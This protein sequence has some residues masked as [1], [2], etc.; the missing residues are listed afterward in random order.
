MIEET[1]LTAAGIEPV[2]IGIRE[3]CVEAI[4]PRHGVI[5]DLSELPREFICELSAVLTC[6]A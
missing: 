2:G 1:S 5:Q 3:A 4:F 6:R